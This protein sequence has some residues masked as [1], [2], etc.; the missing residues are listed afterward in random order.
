LQRSYWRNLLE[1]GGAHGE[2]AMDERE[3]REKETAEIRV[4]L[5]LLFI[6]RSGI[7]V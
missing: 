4:P 7:P 6:S 2:A 5:V 1:L 3:E